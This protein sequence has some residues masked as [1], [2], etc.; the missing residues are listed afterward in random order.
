MRCR[1]CGLVRLDPRPDVAELG[2]IYPPDYYAY[3]LIS[4]EGGEGEGVA[5]RLKRRMYQRRLGAL[6]ERLGKSGPLRLLDVGCADGRLLDWYRSGPAGSSAR[7]PRHRARRARRGDRPPARAPR[8]RGPLRGRRGARA[9][10]LRPDP[11]LPRDRARGR[12]ARPSRAGPPSCSRPAGCSSSRHR[13]G[14]RATRAASPGA[15]AAT[16]PP[17][18]GRSTTSAPCATSPSAWASRSSGPSTSRTRSSGF[19][20]AMRAPA[21]DSPAA[22]GRIGSSRRS[23]SSPPRRAASCCSPDSRCS[24]WS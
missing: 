1:G 15:G 24:T 11:R 7:D 10:L 2:R 5:D 17:G 13:T 14:T 4:E 6:I 3:N 18:T 12:P 16:T 19:G 9:G 22:A 8:R 21:S 20:A 23:R